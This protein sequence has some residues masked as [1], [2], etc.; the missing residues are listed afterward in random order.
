MWREQD[1][2]KAS[3][4]RWTEAQFGPPWLQQQTDRMFEDY[5]TNT[6]T[7]RAAA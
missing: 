1:E 6:N 5:F 7:R 2:R 3:R 4:A